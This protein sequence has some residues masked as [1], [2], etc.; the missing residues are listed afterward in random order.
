MKN[1]KFFDKNPILNRLA[2][3]LL[4]EALD[5]LNFAVDFLQEHDRIKNEKKL[6]LAVIQLHRFIEYIFKYIV[7]EYNPLLVFS[8]V[9]KEKIKLDES[10]TISLQDAINFY[11]N[12]LSFGLIN[13]VS[14]YEPHELKKK[15]DTLVKY[16]NKINHWVIDGDELSGIENHLSSVLQI[17]Y[18]ITLDH[19]LDEKIFGSLGK[20]KQDFIKKYISEEWRKL[21]NALTEVDLYT[22]DAGD[23]KDSDPRESPVFQCPSCGNETFIL[24]DKQKEFYCTYCKYKEPSGDCSLQISC[25]GGPTPES[26]LSVWN[27]DDPEAPPAMACDWCL[28]EFDARVDKA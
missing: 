4:N 15:I 1:D 12:N 17:I 27:N 18:L 16:R 8:N 3:G 5:A 6:K 11:I 21:Q 9:F 26:Y 2:H 7:S 10:K 14:Q 19:D 24:P 13:A 20:D 25:C 22:A 28:D 23:P